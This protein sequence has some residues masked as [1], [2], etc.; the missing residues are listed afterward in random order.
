MLRVS[1]FLAVDIDARSKPSTV[2]VFGFDVQGGSRLPVEPVLGRTHRNWR[3]KG[4][5]GCE[6]HAGT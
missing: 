2:L 6:I 5:S 1:Y 4:N 3:Q